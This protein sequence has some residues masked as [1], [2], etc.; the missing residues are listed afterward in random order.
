M[1][2]SDT[3]R[4]R[5]QRSS[6]LNGDLDEVA[7][8]DRVL[9]AEEVAAAY[10]KGIGG[11][12]LTSARTPTFAEQPQGGTRYASDNFRLSC[13]PADDRGPVTYQWYRSGVPIAGATT[14]VVLLGNLPLGTAN[15]TAVASDGVGSI[16]SAPATLTVVSSAQITS[17]ISAY[18]NFDNNILAQSGTTYNGTAIGADPNP[19]YTNGAIS[20]AVTFTNDASASSVPTD[21]AVS[22]G[23]M[24]SVYSNNWA[25][26][27]WV[28]LT[29]NLDGALLGNK[30]GLREE[31]SAGCFAP[32]NNVQLNYYAVGGPRRDIG[33]VNV[34]NG[35]WHHVACVFNR[36]A[37][38]TYVYVDGS[39]TT[40]ASLSGTGWESLTPSEFLPN[41]TLVGSS[42]NG[43]FSGAGSIDDLGIWS[44]TL[45]AERSWPFTPRAWRANRSPPPW[46]GAPSNP[47]SAP[48]PRLRPS[49]KASVPPFL[50]QLPGR[51]PWLTNGIATAPPFPARRTQPWF[52]TL[53]LLTIRGVTLLSS[54]ISLAR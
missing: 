40:S 49:T 41:D 43:T 42:G 14:R 25:F 2:A 20:S 15:Y 6:S 45:T 8:W 44:R 26:S 27:L 33:N 29:N 53:L 19:K 12:S 36:D 10:A 3:A 31:T 54:P 24:E 13:L 39:L 28:N 34:R 30:I 4:N 18:L 21:W 50:L 11:L 23:D 5:S 52:I 51:P 32:Y 9:T 37:N 48:R 22:L 35:A 17:G 16:T 38:T 46:L 1:P 7:M 47:P